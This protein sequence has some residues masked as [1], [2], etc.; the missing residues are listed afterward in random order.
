MLFYINTIFESIYYTRMTDVQ[1]KIYEVLRQLTQLKV[2]ESHLERTNEEHQ[3]ALIEY[4]ASLKI[5]D[6]NIE[7][8]EALEGFST[9][10]IFYK[11]LGSKKEQEEKARHTL[12]ERSL[13]HQ[14]LKKQIELL[15]YEINILNA[16]VGERPGL[17]RQLAE[18]KGDREKEIVTG[19]PV[20]RAKLLNLS[21]QMEE[22]FS[23]KQEVSEA[24]E[25]GEV[26]LNL[27]RQ[28]VEQLGRASNW[29]NWPTNKNTNGR[30]QQRD[31]IDRARNLS[32]QIKH[33]L[34][35]YDKE[36]SDIGRK[37]DFNL[38]VEGM[39]KFS[40]FFFNNII[41]DWIFRQ[42]LAASISSASKLNGHISDSL[43]FLSNE[44]VQRE[45]I[46]RELTQQHETILLS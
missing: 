34:F 1:S 7:E 36:L 27:S 38:E 25:V 35:L 26:C 31:A 8:V 18:L 10:S 4:D 46:I 44:L 19:D 13:K 20:L 22:N 39:T 41:T 29:G 6:E 30:W 37:L 21:I 28:I 16:K 14:D 24:F 9:R 43:Q 17:E 2:V 15:E 42:Q 3:Q 23:F 11:I 5:L 45:A 40:D 32:Y 33:H 12:L